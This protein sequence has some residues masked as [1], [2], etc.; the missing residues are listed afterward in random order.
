MDYGDKTLLSLQ[1]YITY[2]LIS[3]SQSCTDYVAD[4]SDTSTHTWVSG[5]ESGDLSLRVEYEVASLSEGP[6][7][8]DDD[9]SSS[10]VSVRIIPVVVRYAF[11]NN[12]LLAS[13][14]HGSNVV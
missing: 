9:A 12:L 7:P 13:L 6:N 5:S 10:D 3:N 1:R 8:F 2:L 14:S 4:T 11:V